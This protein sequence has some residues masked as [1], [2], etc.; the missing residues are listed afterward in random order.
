[1]T[2]V[3]Y[4]GEKEIDQWIDINNEWRERTLAHRMKLLIQVYELCKYRDN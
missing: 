4:V 1:M 2:L 3:R